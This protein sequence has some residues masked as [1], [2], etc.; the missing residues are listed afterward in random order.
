MRG[1]AIQSR[2]LLFK[3]SVTDRFPSFSSIKSHWLPKARGS[4]IVGDAWGTEPV[5]RAEAC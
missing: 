1:F 2:R 4:R 3:L 5:S